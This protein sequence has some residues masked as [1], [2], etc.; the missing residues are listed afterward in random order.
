MNR[1]LSH[2]TFLIVILMTIG[3]LFA[4]DGL[5]K[6]KPEEMLIEGEVVDLA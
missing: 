3:Y 1:K 2:I 5:N 6:Q 4:Q